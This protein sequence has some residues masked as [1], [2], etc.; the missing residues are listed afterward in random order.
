MRAERAHESTRESKE[1]FILVGL[2][3]ILRTYARVCVCV[4]FFFT[5]KVP[6]TSTVVPLRLRAY[7]IYERVL[8]S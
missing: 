4:C 1:G 2:V 5:L 3:S 8:V 6:Y 7:G